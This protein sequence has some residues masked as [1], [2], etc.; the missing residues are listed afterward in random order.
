MSMSE[1]YA[2]RDRS[3][4]DPQ[5]AR[6]VSATLNFTGPRGYGQAYVDS[7]ADARTKVLNAIDEGAEVAKYSFENYRPL[8]TFWPLMPL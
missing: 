3:R 7:P 8:L 2:L 6:I 5:L 1:R 4:S